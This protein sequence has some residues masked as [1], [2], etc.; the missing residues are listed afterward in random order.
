MRSTALN[1][2]ETKSYR[3]SDC[4]IG[5]PDSGK[6]SAVDLLLNA[7]LGYSGTDT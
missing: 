6:L 3:P 5:S 1:A 7:R 2:V 4:F